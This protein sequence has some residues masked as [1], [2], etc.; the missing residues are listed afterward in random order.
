MSINCAAVDRLIDSMS[1]TQKVG[2]LNQRLLGWKSVERNAAGRLVASDELKQEIDRW[3]GLGTLYGL[4]RADPW[5]GQ[6]W[7][8]GIRPEERTEAI[9]VVQQTVLE[10]GAHG[11][12]VLLSEEAPHGHQALGGT[13]LDCDAVYHQALREDETLRRRIRDAFGE[14]FRGTELDRQKLGSLVFSDPQALERLNGIIFDYLP[15]VL[16][17]KMEGRVLVGLDAINLIESGLGELCCR[18]VAVLAPGE[19]RV[20]R[21]M[22]RDHIPE[23]YAR[24]RIQAQKPDSYYREHCT[25]VLENQEETP[26]AFR[27]KAE[28]FFRDLLR[29]LHHITE[30]GHEQ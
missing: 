2:Q 29:Q 30:G 15:G 7:G 3:S 5:S 19:Q 6:H 25:D 22:Q 17:R 10:R 23:E 1:F 8:N 26:E 16:R 20:Q 27:E 28:I 9:A 13:V 11:I 4:L 12:G 21:I 14:V 24:L 18:T